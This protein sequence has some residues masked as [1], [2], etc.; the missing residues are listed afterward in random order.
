MVRHVF[1]FINRQFGSHFIIG[2]GS[3]G[4]VAGAGPAIDLHGEAGWR[5][6]FLAGWQEVDLP[7]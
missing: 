7:E 5:G 1:T 2:A 3:G 4:A 6:V